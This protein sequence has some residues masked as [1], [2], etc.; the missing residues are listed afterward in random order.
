MNNLEFLEQ[1]TFPT[2]QTCFF[3][4]CSITTVG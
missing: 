3:I 4:D 2:R 1:Y